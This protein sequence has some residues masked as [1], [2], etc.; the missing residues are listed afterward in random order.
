MNHSHIPP[1]GLKRII[2]CTASLDF[3]AG[4]EL[5]EVDGDDAELGTVAHELAE[6]LLNDKDFDHPLMDADMV[7]HV[8]RYVEYC[9]RLG[10]SKFVEAC[11]DVPE[12]HED[13][14]GT[15]DFGTIAG[16]TLHIVDLKYGM[17]AVDVENNPQLIAYAKGLL[18]QLERDH[19]IDKITMHI[20]QPRAY[21]T[22]GHARVHSITVDELNERV[23]SIALRVSMAC[24]DSALF[25]TGEHCYK[26][27][28]LHDCDAGTQ[29]SYNAIDVI[30]SS[31]VNIN[32]N[33]GQLG[34]DLIMIE[35][36]E[37]VLKD[38]KSSLQDVIEFR[39]KSGIPSSTHYMEMSKGNRKWNV[40]ADVVKAEAM[41]AGVNE[42]DIT[43]TTLQ[44][45]AALEKLGLDKDTVKSM[46]TQPVYSK[47]KPINFKNAQRIFKK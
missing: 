24:S 8:G 23:D 39:L 33:S 13:C 6:H 42:S 20:Y 28:R 15:L 37:R 40:A 3:C 7:Y 9:T 32:S 36:A 44:S 22:D 25:E 41:L 43:K 35:H 45:P 19:V 17:R 21:H 29:A 34:R 14:S 31:R 38:R 5:P 11:V 10:G 47:L 12:I 16:T 30:T 1:S 2:A 4:S 18:N 27:P 26:C 46:I